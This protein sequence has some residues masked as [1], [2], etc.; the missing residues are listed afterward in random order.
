MGYN[1]KQ[2]DDGSTSLVNEAD[3]VEVLKLEPDGDVVVTKSS[4]STHAS[5]SVQPFQ[6]LSTMTGAGGVGGRALFSLA[7]EVAL[8]GW[9]NAVKGL[10]DFGTAGSVTGLGSSVLAELIMGAGCAA[11]SYAPLEI[12]LGMPENAV[13][14]TRT[15]FMSINLYGHATG[16]G[17]FDD[18]GFLFDLNGVT[19]SD[20]GHMFDEVSS[21]AATATARLRVKVNGTTWFIPL[22]ANA[23]LN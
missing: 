6:L 21:Q 9:A 17:R 13:T 4:S 7:T 3:S 16:K 12:E 2:N 8:G 15:S 20:A 14:G 18:N 5:N 19:G 10:T 1:I 22:C 11:G 23:A